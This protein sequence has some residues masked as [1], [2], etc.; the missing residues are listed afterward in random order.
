MIENDEIKKNPK[1]SQI[2][3]YVLNQIR[4]DMNHSSKNIYRTILGVQL[5]AAFLP[6][7]KAFSYY[8]EGLLGA[9]GIIALS[10]MGLLVFC[11]L[12]ETSILQNIVYGP[13]FNY[14]LALM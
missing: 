6:V 11:K 12:N 8:G 3:A 4:I 10:A 1:A 9:K 7:S 5:L 13:K 2:Q 14:Y